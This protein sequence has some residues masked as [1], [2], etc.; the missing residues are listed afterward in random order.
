[1]TDTGQSGGDHICDLRRDSNGDGMPDRLGDYV[2][3]SGTVIA[4]PSTYES[5]GCL[6]WIRDS[7][8]GIMV[9]ASNQRLVIGDS[10]EVLG[11]LRSTSGVYS[12][13][14]TGLPVIGDLAIEAM[15][16]E[17]K[18]AG[19]NQQPIILSL[20]EF[21]ESPQDYAGNLVAIP[22]VYPEDRPAN[23]NGRDFIIWL[24]NG[25]GSVLAYI[26]GDIG[27]STDLLPET[28]FTLTGIVIQLVTPEGFD[29][30]PSWCVAPR[31]RRDLIPSGCS[32]WASQLSWGRLKSCFQD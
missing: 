24:G 3:I 30:N 9:H 7:L 18:G 17:R 4:G 25:H 22:M 16:I 10:V 32:S 29:P 19:A 23:G 21:S 27:Y 15:D 28:C 31:D 6:F 11:F 5:G 14:E 8:C 20:R 2:R 26:D 12:F 13:Q 1:V